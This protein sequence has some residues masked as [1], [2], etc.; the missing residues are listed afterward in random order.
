MRIGVDVSQT[1]LLRAG[2]GNVAYETIRHLA[3][4]D[5]SN[6]YYLY[7]TFGDQFWDENWRQST[8]LPT[9]HN[10]H[11]GLHHD[12]HESLRRFWY[13]PPP[14]L[15]HLLGAP[16]IVHSHN[17]YCPP[18]LRKARLVYTL[19]DLSF[20]SNP[21]WTTE[22]NRIGC[23]RGL[24][25]AS[26][27]ADRIISISE[28]SRR[29]FLSVFP[30]VL[31]E[32][33]EVVPLASRFSSR[34]PI[35]CPERLAAYDGRDFLFSVGTL[36]PR[37]NFFRLTEAYARIAQERKHCPPLLIAGGKGWLF[38][39][40]MKHLADLGIVDKVHMLGFCSEEE[41]QWLMQ[42]CT[43]FLFPSYWEG[44]GLPVVEAMSQG[45]FVITSNVSSMPEVAGDAALLVDPHDTAAIAAAMVR[46]LDDGELR[47][48][49]R[50]RS[51]E[52]A[53]RFSWRQSAERV[54][55]IY[56]DVVARPKYHALPGADTLPEIAGDDA[57][58]MA[59]TPSRWQRLMRR[60]QGRLS[61]GRA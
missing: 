55:R 34:D 27:Y 25:Q 35:A 7:P 6:Q 33:V 28:S 29:H 15:E 16:D 20:I 18:P 26:L 30:H 46:V 56:E 21:E 49:G 60:L 45:A 11:R 32:R 5:H 40:F 59:E 12:T 19:Y 43:F 48:I 54:L 37:K 44:F 41:L 24:F 42:N 57:A 52:Q 53:A 38:N 23:F 31:P 13:Q 1:G 47:R 50:E 8:T 36:E 14:D 4:I 39:G 10:F 22:A 2:C 9:Q 58:V 61:G 51:L 3:D 17:F